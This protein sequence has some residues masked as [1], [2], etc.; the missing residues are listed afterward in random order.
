MMILS[1]ELT[2]GTMFE[3]LYN[4]FQMLILV[5]DEIYIFLKFLPSHDIDARFI[6]DSP[7]LMIV[8][9]QEF[10]SKIVN[11]NQ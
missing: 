10:K 7:F 8:S 5:D 6:T 4:K 3:Y 1:T 9:N 2:N 11:F